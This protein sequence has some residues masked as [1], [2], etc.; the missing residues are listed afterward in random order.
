MDE[1]HEAVLVACR[2][3]KA[4]VSVTHLER[5]IQAASD[6]PSVSKGLSLVSIRGPFGP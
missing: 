6:G 4:R 1:L 5:N 3:A 2:A